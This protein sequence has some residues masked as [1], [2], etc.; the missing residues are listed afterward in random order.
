M[1][2]TLLGSEWILW[3]LMALSVVSVAV[4]VER[5]LYFRRT[6]V[7]NFPAFFAALERT[8]RGRDVA[9]ATALCKRRRS[10]EAKVA[11]TALVNRE[12]HKDAVERLV[13][14]CVTLERKHLD[15]G[16]SVLGTL[17]NN[18][19][20]IGLL[21]TV[22]GIIT[23]FRALA[24]NPAGGSAVVMAGISEALVATAVGLLVAIPAVIAFNA[25]QRTIKNRLANA[26]AVRDLVLAHVVELRAKAR[27]RE[28]L[29]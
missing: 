20:F 18:T 11:L 6:S 24:A 23:A 5:A 12:L 16:L 13:E 19:P 27:D 1:V 22:I 8:L 15:R 3:L 25:F 26:N 2:F 29:S 7:G 4:M 17:G 10:F 28:K 21:G 14:S 9:S